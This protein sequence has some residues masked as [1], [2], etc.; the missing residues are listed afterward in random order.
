MADVREHRLAE[1]RRN[2][3]SLT[4]GRLRAAQPQLVT[5]FW[6]AS[7]LLAIDI[8]GHDETRPNL[9]APRES[10]R[11]KENPEIWPGPTGSSS[12]CP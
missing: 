1:D 12:R 6:V 11:G 5:P 8:L 2:P 10:S 3:A 4:R 9:T 7:A